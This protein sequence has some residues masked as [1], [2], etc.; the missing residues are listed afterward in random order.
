[1]TAEVHGAATTADRALVK[2]QRP[3]EFTPGWTK[4]FALLIPPRVVERPLPSRL[5][6]DERI[7]WVRGPSPEERLVFLI[8]FGPKG[9]DIHSVLPSLG[10]VQ[11]I[12]Q[13]SL[14]AEDVWLLAAYESSTAEER[15]EVRR[16]FESLRITLTPG[17]KVEEIGRLFAHSIAADGPLPFARDHEIGEE[18][19]VLPHL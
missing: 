2:W 13:L 19:L 15:D 1:M 12:G 17:A 14:P 9:G 4:C 8:V 7:L 16:F 3:V 18:H 11:V 5:S 10:D 6:D